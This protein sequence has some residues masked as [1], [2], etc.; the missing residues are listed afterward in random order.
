MKH[1]HPHPGFF[2]NLISVF[3]FIAIMAGLFFGF[4]KLYPVYIDRFQ[5]AQRE[6]QKESPVS[7]E[8][9]PFVRGILAGK[10]TSIDTANASD[11][12]FDR[13]NIK[14][15]ELGI[16][17]ALF[18][19]KDW[20]DL[21]R[22]LFRIKGIA[23][24]TSAGLDMAKSFPERST[25]QYQLR[26]TEEIQLAINTNLEDLLGANASN[27]ENV[28]SNFLSGLKKLNAEAS[29]EIINLERRTQESR[30]VM[31]EN[32]AL[33]EQ[34]KDDLQTLEPYLEARKKAEE[35]RIGVSRTGK[36]LSR[37]RSLQTALNRL[38]QGIENNYEAL[39]KGVKVTPIKGLSLPILKESEVE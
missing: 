39:S 8:I 18:T 30:I 11:E 6:K 10:D 9:A 20:F 23:D 1:D 27:R 28:L 12:A 22:Q 32:T 3:F 13:G 25:F 7:K 17:G 33:S 5:T 31:E 34:Y 19:G 38:I 16:T 29:V 14:G 2:P 36:V 37:L 4:T 21:D 26:L 24:G 15:Y 35:A